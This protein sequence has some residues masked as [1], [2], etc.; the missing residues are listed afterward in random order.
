MRH[1]IAIAKAKVKEKLQ[2]PF[3]GPRQR[4][5]TDIGEEATK[6]GLGTIILLGGLFGLGG[7]VCLIVGMIRSGGIDG[8]VDGWMKAM[9]GL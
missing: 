6:A 2:G 9:T 8:L 5:E 7:F 4:S 1:A 3:Q